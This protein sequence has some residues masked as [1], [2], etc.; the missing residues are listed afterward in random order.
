MSTMIRWKGLVAAAALTAAFAV[1]A[2]S[3]RAGGASPQAPARVG[4]D[5]GGEYVVAYDMAKAEQAM[6]AIANAGGKVVDVQSQIGLA[7]VDA[8]AGFGGKV[9]KD[10]SI[11]GAMIDES[12]GATVKGRQTVRA[13]ERLTAVDGAQRSHGKANG[14]GKGNGKGKA[15]A[16][17]P[18]EPLQWDM[19]MIGATREAAQ[20]KA[21]GTRRHCRRHRHRR[22]RLASRHRSELQLVTEPQLHPRPPGHRR[23]VRRPDVHRP[24]RHRRRRPWHA[25]RR[26]HRRRP[27]RGGHRR[28]GARRHDRRGPRRTGLRLLLPVRDRGRTAVRG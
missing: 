3:A 17:D 27:Q 24:D 5:D 12:I 28:R 25:C 16:D 9:A 1:P 6:R 26:H 18:L 22:R 19:Q 21:T 4:R 7:L 8:G 2:T 23:A 20:K 14:N 13:T 10:A 11:T 15:K